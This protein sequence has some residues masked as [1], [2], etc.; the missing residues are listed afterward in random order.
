MV[1]YNAVDDAT[2]TP[3]AAFEIIRFVEVVDTTAPLI[4]LTDANPQI[5]EAC[6]PYVEL[7]ATCRKP[8]GVRPNR[9]TS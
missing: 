4:I 1:T 3:N 8:F 2:P 7:G 9:V 5:I 6:T